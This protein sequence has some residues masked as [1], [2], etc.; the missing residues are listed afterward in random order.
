MLYGRRTISLRRGRGFTLV[1]LMTVSFIL[2]MIMGAIMATFTI[3]NRSMALA[4]QRVDLNQTAHLITSR[5]ER[6]LSSLWAP[7]PD[8]DSSET[9]SVLGDTLGGDQQAA[10]GATPTDMGATEE[11]LTPPLYG[12]PGDV[13]RDESPRIEFL[14]AVPPSFETNRQRTDVVQVIY[15]VDMDPQTPEKGLIRGVNRHVDLGDAE[16][17]T[18]FEVLSEH[19]ASFEVQYYNP[20]TEE[21]EAAWESQTLPMAI[22]FSLVFDNEEDDEGPI[23]L[24]GTVTPPRRV[25]A[26]VG[27]SFMGG[28]ETGAQETMQPT[29]QEGG[30]GGGAA[31]MDQLIDTIAGGMGP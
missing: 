12:Y 25:G 22:L 21:F 30:M 4:D 15:Y 11:G 8:P 31:Q 5:L 7:F 10:T 16:D 27:E 13:A 17:T 28:Q 20:E 18:E 2:A 3:G 19:V 26:A 14:M 29:E 23:S 6:E 1:E 9:L 24:I